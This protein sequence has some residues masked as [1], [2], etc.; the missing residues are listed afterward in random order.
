MVGCCVDSLTSIFTLKPGAC[1]PVTNV[2]FGTLRVIC[3][4]TT[5]ATHKNTAA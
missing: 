2:R 4:A 3:T 5:A 1:C